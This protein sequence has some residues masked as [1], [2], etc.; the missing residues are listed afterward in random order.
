[1]CFQTKPALVCAE[2]APPIREISR[3][4]VILTKNPHFTLSAKFHETATRVRLLLLDNRDQ[5]FSDFLFARR[6]DAGLLFRYRVKSPSGSA[7][8]MTATGPI[9]F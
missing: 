7:W 6:K 5:P 1:M 3:A 9:V 4:P 8:P 2:S